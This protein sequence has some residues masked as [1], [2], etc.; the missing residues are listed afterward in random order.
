MSDNFKSFND[1]FSKDF[2]LYTITIEDTDNSNP[3]IPEEDGDYLYLTIPKDYKCIYKQLL[4][5]LS[6][7][8]VDMLNDCTAV[9]GGKNK[10]IITCWNMFQAACASY[11]LGDIKKADLLI[12]YIKGQLNIECSSS[13]GEQTKTNMIYFGQTDD[14]DANTFSTLNVSDVFALNKE[15]IEIK[16]SD[17]NEVTKEQTSKL[18][19]LI[20][21]VDLG[22]LIEVSYKVGD[23]TDYLWNG[24]ESTSTYKSLPNV[25]Q[26]N[27]IKYKVYFTYSLENVNL[28]INIKIKNK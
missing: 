24:D 12:N 9:C 27:S 7:L 16:G 11:E 18:H 17:V 22:D 21:P 15:S 28:N 4:V 25:E 3:N 8:G 6:Q 5:K 1:S 14:I 10:F 26:I 23:L 2:N 20:I 19:F 13:T